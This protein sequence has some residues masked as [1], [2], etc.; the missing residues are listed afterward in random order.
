V[1]KITSNQAKMLTFK[2]NFRAANAPRKRS[3]DFYD[4]FGQVDSNTAVIDDTWLFNWTN[5]PSVSELK[6]EITFFR[7]TAGEIA[8]NGWTVLAPAAKEM[9]A[10]F[11][12][13]KPLARND[14]TDK[15]EPRAMNFEWLSLNRFRRRPCQIG[16]YNNS[17][18]VAASS[19]KSPKLAFTPFSLFQALQQH[20]SLQNLKYRLSYRH[21]QAS[22]DIGRT[23]RYY[24]NSNVHGQTYIWAVITINNINIPC[25]KCFTLSAELA[26]LSGTI[27]L[28]NMSCGYFLQQLESALILPYGRAN[29]FRAAINFIRG[30]SVPYYAVENLFNN[31][32]ISKCVTKL[33]LLITILRAIDVPA[34]ELLLPLIPLSNNFLTYER[35][36]YAYKTAS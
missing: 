12:I 5:R 35:R 15:T 3:E 19:L 2:G 20:K 29:V 36:Q 27:D 8:K 25:P 17:H 7:C 21:F 4:K 32:E 1:G 33:D 34:E 24:L 28:L 30:T 16:L 14:I 13:E 26:S 22:F 11:N 10:A 18:V 6:K 23:L 31:K 9:C